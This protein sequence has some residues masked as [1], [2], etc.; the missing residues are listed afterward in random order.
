LAISWAPELE[1]IVE[2]LNETMHKDF[3][4]WLTSMPTPTFPV[5][6]LQSSIKMTLE[7]PKGLRSNLLRTYAKMDDHELN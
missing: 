7:P 5:Y 3:R 2:E 6:V 4:L 1:K